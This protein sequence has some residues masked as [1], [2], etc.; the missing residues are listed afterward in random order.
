[1]NPRFLKLRY[2]KDEDEKELEH[3]PMSSNELRLMAER[4]AKVQ[5]PLETDIQEEVSFTIEEFEEANII[6]LSLDNSLTNKKI[7]NELKAAAKSA[8]LPYV[9]LDCLKKWIK[10]SYTR[11]IETTLSNLRATTEIERLDLEQFNFVRRVLGIKLMQLRAGHGEKLDSLMDEKTYISTI[12]SPDFEILKFCFVFEFPSSKWR[13]ELVYRTCSSV[14]KTDGSLKELTKLCNAICETFWKS[15]SG[16][17]TIAS[18]YYVL[19]YV[20]H[21][22]FF[23]DHSALLCSIEILCTFDEILSD[24]CSIIHFACYPI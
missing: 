23:N 9:N 2:E 13:R 19:A 22:K 8:P 3:F 6:N 5:Q 4:E 18:K 7:F 14:R 20:V 21:S 1:M 16:D 24:D 12:V 10:E 15:K 11:K 17:A